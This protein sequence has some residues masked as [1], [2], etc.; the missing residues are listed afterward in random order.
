[1][2]SLSFPLCSSFLALPLEGES[3]KIFRRVI[4]ELDSFSNSLR[5]QNPETPHVTLQFWKEL[6]EIE[7]HQVVTQAEKIALAS[8]PFILKT[9]EPVTFSN[10]GRDQ[11]LFLDIAFS[12]ELARLKKSCPWPEGKPFHPHLTIARIKHAGRFAVAEK[13]VM[14]ILEEV[15]L[16]IP[17][18][19]LRLYAKVEGVSQTPLQDFN[20][21][22]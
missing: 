19:R 7:Y 15:S 18:D 20:F 10:R 5:F 6:M 13:K 21:A 12:D 2:P 1:M 8:F 14:K 9:T 17:V 4:E 11:V 16:T 3:K 22:S